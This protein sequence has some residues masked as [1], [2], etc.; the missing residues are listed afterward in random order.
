MNELP[1]LF[2]IEEV[3]QSFGISRSKAYELKRRDRWPSTE[4]G[5]KSFRFTAEQVQAITAMYLKQP[6]QPT[7]R[8]PRVGTR[9]NRS[10]S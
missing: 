2:T 10:K 3:C 1:K 8:T 6:K 4:F 7:K 9:A 5:E